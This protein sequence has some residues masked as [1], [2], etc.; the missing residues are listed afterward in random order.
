MI[1]IAA[2]PAGDQLSAD[3]AEGCSALE[4]EL[5]RVFNPP[6]DT[7]VNQDISE[8]PIEVRPQPTS[9]PDAPPLPQPEQPTPTPPPTPTPS[10]TPE[11][12]RRLY[13]GTTVS[14]VPRI[15]GGIDLFAGNALVDFGQGFYTT[16]SLVHAERRAI[17]MANG[18]K[19]NAAVVVFDVPSDQ[20]NALHHLVFASADEAWRAFVLYHRNIPGVNHNYDWIEGPVARKWIGG[21]EAWPYREYHQL[22]IHTEAAR[23]LFQESITRVISVR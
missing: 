4:R 2:S 8:M 20:L 1:A 23:Q 13:H 6:G 7:V 11:P 16:E 22:S 17:Q 19:N 10:P 14:D 3:I 21:V 9:R 12:K 18:D 15:L 5:E